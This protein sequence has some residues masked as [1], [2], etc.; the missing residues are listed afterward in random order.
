[1][2]FIRDFQKTM[3]IPDLKNEID[4]VMNIRIWMIL[5]EIHL[6]TEAEIICSLD[7]FFSCKFSR[8]C[9]KNI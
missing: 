1:M 6:L 2:L 3:L 9:G 4:S 8:N 7:K 5:F